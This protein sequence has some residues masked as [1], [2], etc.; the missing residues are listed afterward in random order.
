MVGEQKSE[1]F[2]GQIRGRMVRAEQSHSQEVKLMVSAGEGESCMRT[3]NIV[4]Y[5]V[6]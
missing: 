2:T 6:A 4:L 1:V 3:N 5:V